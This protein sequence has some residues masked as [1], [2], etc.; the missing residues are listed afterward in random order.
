MLYRRRRFIN[1]LLTYLLTY[2]WF[3]SVTVRSEPCCV[4]LPAIIVDLYMHILYVFG[5]TK[6]R[7]CQTWSCEISG[8][9]WTRAGSWIDRTHVGLQSSLAWTAN[10]AVSPVKADM[11]IT[12]TGCT[13]IIYGCRQM[14][15]YGLLLPQMRDGGGAWWDVER[16]WVGFQ[17]VCERLL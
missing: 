14:L 17:V 7:R 4:G 9:E 16:G 12:L 10:N 3:H 6:C 11:A 8:C 13:V 1:H 2:L 15:M 5:A